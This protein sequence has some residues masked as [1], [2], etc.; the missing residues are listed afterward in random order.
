M[1]TYKQISYDRWPAT[2]DNI[3]ELSNCLFYWLYSSSWTLI[4]G[5]SR[6][7]FRHV[8]HR[9]Q[10]HMLCLAS[11]SWFRDEFLADESY[12]PSRLF[13]IGH[14]N[15]TVVLMMS[16]EADFLRYSTLTL[17]IVLLILT[18]IWVLGWVS[19]ITDYLSLAIIELLGAHV[20]H[21]NRN[22]T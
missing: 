20:C 18:Q 11:P 6:D 19:C 21:Q 3:K 16:R 7:R 14:E 10:V 12:L 5:L 2:C 4:N 17:A 1:F 13:H 22:S 9:D 8:C 15:R